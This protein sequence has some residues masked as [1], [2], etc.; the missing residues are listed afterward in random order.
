MIPLNPFGTHPFGTPCAVVALV[1]PHEMHTSL[2]GKKGKLVLPQL[3]Q[4]LQLLLH[5]PECG[6]QTS[7]GL[8]SLKLFGKVISYL[9]PDLR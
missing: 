8:F 7:T 2:T 9:Q 3:C 6:P 5:F 4:A 1:S